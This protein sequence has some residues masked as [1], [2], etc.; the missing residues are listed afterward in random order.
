MTY[1]S[2]LLGPMVSDKASFALDV[3]KA[4]KKHQGEGSRMINE[5]SLR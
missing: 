1:L 4:L 3:L 5:A 2:E